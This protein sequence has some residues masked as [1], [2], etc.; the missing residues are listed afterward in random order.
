MKQMLRQPYSYINT[1][2]KMGEPDE[3]LF[4]YRN[5]TIGKDTSKYNLCDGKMWLQEL[6]FEKKI[7][8]KP[9]SM[10]KSIMWVFSFYK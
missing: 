9:L 7:I 10:F 4:I 6:M 5:Q 3:K 2:Y 8:T 1:Q